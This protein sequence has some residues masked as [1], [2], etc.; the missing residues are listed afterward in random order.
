MLRWMLLIG[1][2]LLVGCPRLPEP[3][4]CTPH[5]Y[6]CESDRPQVCSAT[7]RWTPIGDLRCA[8]VQA[9]CAVADGVASCAPVTRDGGAE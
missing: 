6:R 8:E 3:S 7:Q 1:L 4:G 9:V 5:V 2:A